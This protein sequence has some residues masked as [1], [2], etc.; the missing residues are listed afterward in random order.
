LIA[1][2]RNTSRS[3]VPILGSLPIVG[4]AFRFDV[5]SE[6]R[7]ELLV[8]LTPRIVQTDEDYENLK[9]VE[10][11][12]ISWCLA[13]A[14]N[15]HGDVGLSGGNGLWG[16]PRGGLMMP[17]RPPI[18]IPDRAPVD[19]ENNYPLYGGEQYLPG[20][21]IPGPIESVPGE[22]ED[23][24]V[25]KQPTPMLQQASF[26]QLQQTNSNLIP[27]NPP[28]ATTEQPTPASGASVQRGSN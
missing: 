9:Q 11:S 27:L 3:Q 13:D 7:K 20:V 5:E 28:A 16:P 10:S 22:Y 8:V 18:K 1:K 12:R 17:D 24:S 19:L 21:G 15:M 23:L 2:N 14:V 6:V 4:A 26:R 25:S